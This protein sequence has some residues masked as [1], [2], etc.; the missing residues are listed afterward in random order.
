MTGRVLA[1]GF[2]DG[3]HAGH[4]ALLRETARI[5]ACRGLDPAAVTFR[6]RVAGK[7]PRQLT[8]PEERERLIRELYG[9]ETIFLTFDDA[10]R[11]TLPDD[12]VRLLRDRFRAVHLVAGYD[13]TFGRQ[14]M[15]NAGTLRSCCEALG[16]GCTVIDGVLLDGA[17]VSTSRI[18]EML[19]AGRLEKAA[20]LLGHPYALTLELEEADGAYRSRCLP[21]EMLLPA[22][23]AYLGSTQRGRI[24]A[25]VDGR[26]LR[27]A[28]PGAA[29]GTV[30][31][32]LE[33]EA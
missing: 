23:G 3:V 15:G 22:P 12:F 6:G 24:F 29:G 5:A 9:L 25:E 33:R 20:E 7:P 16:L 32:L 13:F 14:G 30:R 11:D 27:V 2:F 17:P 1:L 26:G 18:R 10:L 19:A 8:T 31:L 4:G 28:G 21:E